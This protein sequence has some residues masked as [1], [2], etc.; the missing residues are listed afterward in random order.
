MNDITPIKPPPLDL[1]GRPAG[2]QAFSTRESP[3][4]LYYVETLV[5]WT[6]ETLIPYV[7]ENVAGLAGSWD[8]QTIKL[9]DAWTAET[10]ELKTSW[11]TQS[12]ELI[13][14]VE[15]IAAGTGDAVAATQAAQAAAEAAR[16]LAEQYAS[17]AATVQDA[18]VTTLFNDPNS[19]FRRATD[20]A[21]AGFDDVAE[22][23]EVIA[24][25]G[26]T[27][28]DKTATEAALTAMTER[29]DDIM[30]EVQEA[31]QA[32]LGDVASKATQTTV[33]TGRLSVESLKASAIDAAAGNPIVPTIFT[34]L[35]QGIDD[36]TLDTRVVVLGS[37]TTQGAFTQMGSQ[38]YAHRLANRCGATGLPNLET[39][40]A[41]PPA[42]RMRWWRG[43]GS[44]SSNYLSA[45]SRTAIGHIKPQY[46]LHM[47]GSNDWAANVPLATYRANVLAAIASM[48]A[49]S[50][51]SIH[52]LIHGQGRRDV[53]PS[54]AWVQYG[55]ELAVIAAAAPGKRVYLDANKYFK[56]WDIQGSNRGA[57]VGRDNVHM[58]PQGHKLMAD[59]L[60]KLMGILS[61]DMFIGPV[62]GSVPVPAAAT[63]T[64][65]S[66]V[67]AN[68]PVQ[69]A[70]YP[71]LMRVS[72]TFFTR[73]T[74]NWALVAS[75]ITS[76]GGQ[77]GESFPAGGKA[78]VHPPSP[79]DAD[80]MMLNYDL[81]IDSFAWGDV[82]IS[83]SKQGGGTSIYV[84]GSENFSNVVYSIE[85]A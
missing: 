83:T 31:I 34:R 19:Q 60:S 84:S 3:T 11:A 80:S 49:V 53:S 76:R 57:I 10:A 55:N 46:I 51:N 18:S 45:A 54:T 81:T 41:P 1:I 50:P 58:G 85:A 65:D 48:D 20:L 32:G 72:A 64:A 37:S 28:A 62:S 67:L 70:S 82:E 47:I 43:Q 29:L 56:P 44:D 30:I 4:M 79:T 61:E 74:G 2:V 42:G 26:D 23:M 52:V 22:I 35:W 73:R 27:Y 38:N 17:E 21:Y 71:R 7:D 68:I 14:Q 40:T 69:P 78:I 25:L 9:I 12:A 66:N 63:Y 33:E 15:E 36:P 24:G 77:M 5:K 13:Q 16:D 59:T 8:E 39:V 75:L 6:T